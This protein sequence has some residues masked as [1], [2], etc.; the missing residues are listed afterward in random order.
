MPINGRTYGQTGMTKL[1]IALRNF[2]NSSDKLVGSYNGMN[3]VYC[4][5]RNGSLNT[6]V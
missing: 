5:V 3:S 4:A 6:T 2:S 1:I